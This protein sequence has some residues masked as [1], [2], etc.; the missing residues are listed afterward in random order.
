MNGL[1]PKGRLVATGL[2]LASALLLG[3]LSACVVGGPGY[4]RG[5]G[6]YVGGVYEAPG[7]VYGGWGSD[8]RVGPARDDHARPDASAG[9]RTAPSIPNR[10]RDH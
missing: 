1:R 8:Y 7:A 9:R 4:S 6:V 10:Q 3:A 2:L 5:G